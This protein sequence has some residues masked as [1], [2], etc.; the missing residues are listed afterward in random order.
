MILAGLV[1]LTT[2]FAGC[3]KNTKA[4]DKNNVAKSIVSVESK[5]QEGNK[6]TKEDIQKIDDNKLLQMTQ[7]PSLDLEKLE[8]SD[9]ELSQ[10]DSI[11]N[12]KEPL[13]DISKNI[14]LKK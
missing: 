13:S 7:E 5:Q 4:E 10:L 6:M 12:D 11:L 8:D 3:S 1:V 2:L 9:E 14:E